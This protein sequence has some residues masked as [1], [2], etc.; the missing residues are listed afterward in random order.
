M[1]SRRIRQLCL[2]LPI[3]ISCSDGTRGM[4]GGSDDEKDSPLVDRRL[5]VAVGAVERGDV[6]DHLETTGILESLSQAQIIP[7]V[8]GRVEEI[9][10][11]EGDW[12]ESGQVLALIGNPSIEASLDR[13]RIERASA[14]Q[15]ADKARELFAQGAISQLE[16]DQALDAEKTA[17]ISWREATENEGFTKIKAPISGEVVA[18][19]IH[20]GEQAGGAR[21]FHL[22]DT[23]SLRVITELPELDLNKLKRDQ[24]VELS[25]AYEVRDSETGRAERPIAVKGHVE[26]VGRVIDPAK[27][28]ARVIIGVDDEAD[29]RSGQFLRV[30][31][32]VD[33]HQDVL[34]VP[35]MAVVWD[36]FESIAWQIVDAPEEVI[37]DSMRMRRE[38][39]EGENGDEDAEEPDLSAWDGVPMRMARKIRVDLGY[40]DDR[41]VEIVDGL[42]E[43]EV[44]VLEGNTNLRE[45]S[46]LRLPDDPDLNGLDEDQG[47]PE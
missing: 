8:T 35:R 13:A 29:L 45:K 15:S 25:S 19:D 10:V 33:V 1:W 46:L 23:R 31:I 21:A 32:Q 27:G 30:R 5:L 47:N 4:G 37:I 44:V 16:F 14:R 6:A 17:D 39:K 43:G 34:R 36:G 11:T 24:V 22:V 40:Q 9:T 26:Y 20:V 28:T 12:V 3:L 7:E 38:S 41:W 2:A 18:I 42:E